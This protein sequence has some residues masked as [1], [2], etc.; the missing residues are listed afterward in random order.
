MS[1]YIGYKRPVRAVGVL[2]WVCRHRYQSTTS[3]KFTTSPGTGNDKDFAT[4]SSNDKGITPLIYPR[5]IPKDSI[6][7]ISIPVTTTRSFIY[8]NHSH[9]S[10]VTKVA[11]PSI[12]AK[13][14][15]KVT[16][17]AAK[18]WNKLVNSDL[19]VNKVIISF[20][21]KLLNTVPYD[22][23]SLKSFP[24]K[25][26]MIREVNQ[27]FLKETNY[28]NPN[29]NLLT[30]DQLNELNVPV[31]QLKPI[32][33]YHPYFQ[34]PSTILSQL[35]QFR[36][37]NYSKHFKYSILC[38]IGIPITLPLALLPVVPNVPGFYL[39]YRLY[40]HLKAFLG[41]KH[42]DYLLE[43]RNSIPNK[44]YTRLD[45]FADDESVKDSSHL[46]FVPVRN[47][48]VIYE[49]DN[50]KL[51]DDPLDEESMILTESVIDRIVLELDLQ[52]LK[53]ELYRALAQERKRVAEEIKVDDT[54]G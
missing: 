45:K 27:E 50:R 51:V 14:E 39:A 53:D 40:C 38:A 5:V 42:L 30:M 28:P 12:P 6:Y 34:K 31:N 20:V 43:E 22:E 2:R 35:Y 37:E 47:L 26:A 11:T 8:C 44:K 13:F 29:G 21:N 25:N 54:I 52:H 32:P 48:D 41:V 4:G 7:V 23:A 15:A 10:V 18:G 36:D 16:G 9:T 24:P 3:S 1:S 17:L 19:K 33:L 49:R 46:M